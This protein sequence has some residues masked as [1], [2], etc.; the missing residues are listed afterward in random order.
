MKFKFDAVLEG[1]DG[2]V[3]P[4][5][6]EVRAPFVGGQSSLIRLAVPS[7]H[8]TESPPTSPC[9][10]S[11]V[12]GRQ[13]ITMQGVHW[14]HFPTSS[15]SVLGLNAIELTFVERLTIRQPSMSTS[16]EIRFHLAPISFLRSEASFVHYGDRSHQEEL[17]VLDLPGLG[18]TRFAAEW[19]TTYHRDADI[20]GATVVAGFCAIATLP[21]NERFDIDR[22]VATFKSSLEVLSVLFR[23][24]VSVHGWT[25]T[26]DETISTWIY[27]LEPI[28]APCAREDRGD[29]VARPQEFVECATSLAKAY[30]NA[31]EQV[32]SLV[33]H[34]C[35][36]VNP[37]TNRRTA[38]RFSSM[39]AAIERVTEAAWKQ[40]HAFHV[41]AAT[42]AI[43]IGHLEQLRKAV[44][45]QGGEN[46]AETAERLGGLVRIVNQPSVR[47]KFDAFFRAYPAM[48]S[49]CAD[50][51]PL[52]GSDKER[53]LREI[54]NSLAHGR[55]S[56]MSPDVVAVAEWHL[57]ILL[58][59]MIF[60]L[61]GVPLPE[62]VAPGDFLLRTGG[63]GWYERESWMPLRS[64]PDLPI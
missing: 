49:Y 38:D 52:L 36:T 9:A 2:S 42:T 43:V 40:S 14:R 60:V 25:Y 26:D 1:S 54:R 62:G 30:G 22:T 61:L 47:D 13:K 3:L 64:K 6:C 5:H 45:E 27:P 23:Q 4:V 51:W 34:L 16:R 58:E 57:A 15:R 21:T 55:S 19:T 32:R 41:K 18:L 24:S 17:F 28:L 39:F 59:R 37:H 10:L 8:V 20:P 48:A 12:T 63:R 33:R 29:F 7:S 56:F 53:G 31:G 11:G 50:L 35:L 44:C 46:A